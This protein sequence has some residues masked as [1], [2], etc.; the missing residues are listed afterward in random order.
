MEHIITIRNEDYTLI[1]DYKDQEEFRQS[2]NR[3]TKNTYCF[4][5]EDWYRAGYWKE[6][7]IP[8]SL[9]HQGEVVANVS[10]NRM[11]F[12]IDNTM[13]PCLQ[14][15]TVM[16]AEEYRNK[17]LSRVLMEIILKEFQGS[18]QL[19]YLYANDSVL[20]F[21]PKFG[22][23]RAE[24]YVHSRQFIKSGKLYS[25]RKL[26]M[27]TAEDRDRMLRLAVNTLPV[28]KISMVGNPGLSMFYLT[29]FMSEDIYYFEDLNL[30]A[31]AETEGGNLYLMDV[32][33][34]GEFVLEEVICSLMEKE[35]MKVTL[36]FT[37][38]HTT[39]YDCTVLQEEGS[40]FFV[41][42]N[43]VLE[44]GRFPILSHA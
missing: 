2:L 9:V 11:D 35:Q 10:V 19:I 44:N 20:E 39:E 29:K 17:G 24:E 23:T 40:T 1:K 7:Y 32:F 25:Y 33:C 16:T 14:I 37:P 3:L 22:F 42:G 31:V 30:A 13:V 36:G 18:I 4:D 43:N 26:D 28:S 41:K 8:Y 12:L 27:K 21:Y 15:G 5:F 6:K 34:P 38:K